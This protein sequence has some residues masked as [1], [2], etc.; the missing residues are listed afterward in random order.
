MVCLG[1]AETK[2]RSGEAAKQIEKCDV[3]LLENNASIECYNKLIILYSEKASFFLIPPDISFMQR[4][5][6]LD[7][8]ICKSQIKILGLHQDEDPISLL[9]E[10]LV[11]SEETRYKYIVLDIDN[12]YM[13][14]FRRIRTKKSK[15]AK[16]VEFIN[17]KIVQLQQGDAEIDLVVVKKQESNMK[18]ISG[19]APIPRPTGE[20]SIYIGNVTIN[21]YYYTSNEF[22]LSRA[23]FERELEKLKQVTD[24][25][26][27]KRLM[28]EALDAVK[29][30]NEGKFKCALKK[31]G[32]FIIENAASFAVNFVIEYMK[33][34]QLGGL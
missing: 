6:F 4:E 19:F 16:L 1:I 17:D 25:H 7:G 28:D 29:T 31:A 13:V 18:D 30:G 11:L 2:E 24:D 26:N 34:N 3:I 14:A 27:K 9:P 8:I 33:K 21:N 5:L 32:S 20:T 15:G 23:Q 12:P 22:N 10:I